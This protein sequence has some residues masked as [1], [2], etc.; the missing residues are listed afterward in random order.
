[1]VVVS[2]WSM[3]QRIGV[4]LVRDHPL[5]SFLTQAD[6]QTSRRA[7]HLEQRVAIC[8][9]ITRGDT[10]FRQVERS[11]TAPITV[12]EQ[13]PRL[14]V[15]V[16]ALTLQRQRHVEHHNIVRMM[17]QDAIQVLRACS[18]RPAFKQLSNLTLFAGC[19]HVCLRGAPSLKKNCIYARA[20]LVGRKRSSIV[21]TEWCSCRI[22]HSPSILWSPTVRRRSSGPA[23]VPSQ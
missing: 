16:D 11:W 17:C 23:D 19:G 6:G 20:E 3:R 7:G 4:V 5:A 15:R 21:G 12:K 10:Q 13:L 18:L 22:V 9:G 2:D 1:M 14:P 8:D